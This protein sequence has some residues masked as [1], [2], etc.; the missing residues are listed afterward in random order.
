[1]CVHFVFW[2]VVLIFI[3]LGI[4]NIFRGLIN[5]LRKNRIA[6]KQ[7]LEMNEDVV[8]EENRVG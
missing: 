6:P 2:S 5:I 8:E 3:E 4:F 1:M 7:N